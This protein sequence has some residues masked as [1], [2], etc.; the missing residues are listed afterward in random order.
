[1][2]TQEMLNQRISSS[3]TKYLLIFPNEQ[4]KQFYKR[5]LQRNDIIYKTEREIENSGLVGMR[6]INWNYVDETMTKQI[7]N[8][9]L[10][11]KGELKC[12]E[13]NQKKSK[14]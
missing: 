14:D 6:Y 10:K 8:E 13:E 11:R 2:I 7:I 12:L 5:W 1:M 3:A 9:K 4:I